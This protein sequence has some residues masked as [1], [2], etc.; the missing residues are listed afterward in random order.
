[1]FKSA[2]RTLRARSVALVGA[3][4]RAKWPRDIYASLRDGGQVTGR[5]LAADER[6]VSLDTERG[7]ATLSYPELVRGAVQVEFATAGRADEEAPA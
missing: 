2:E 4:E 6:A 3:S 5:V 1:M 7:P